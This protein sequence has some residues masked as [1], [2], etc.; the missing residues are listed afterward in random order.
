MGDWVRDAP[1]TEGFKVSPHVFLHPYPC[2]D[3][4]VQVVLTGSPPSALRAEPPIGCRCEECFHAVM[5]V[6][7]LG[8]DPHTAAMAGEDGCLNAT[9]MAWLGGEC[10]SEAQAGVTHVV[11]VLRGRAGAEAGAEECA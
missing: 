5:A 9:V 2:G 3:L 10:G 6:W 7:G 8:A 1:S 4:M 11:V